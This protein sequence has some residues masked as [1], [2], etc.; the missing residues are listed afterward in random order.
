MSTIPYYY[1]P[2]EPNYN[3]VP[4]NFIDRFKDPT[5]FDAGKLI[6]SC[7]IHVTFPYFFLL[8][9]IWVTHIIRRENVCELDEGLYIVTIGSDLTFN[10]YDC[11]DKKHLLSWNSQLIT[12]SG[13]VRSIVYLEAEGEELRG[14]SILWMSYPTSEAASFCTHLNKL[15]NVDTFKRK[16]HMLV[17]SLVHESQ[18]HGSRNNHGSCDSGI[19]ESLI[20]RTNS[21]YKAVLFGK[22]SSNVVLNMYTNRPNKKKS[23]NSMSSTCNHPRSKPT[24]VVHNKLKH[25]ATGTISRS[26]SCEWSDSSVDLHL[27]SLESVN[28]S[29]IDCDS[30]TES[31]QL[32]CNDSQIEKH[33][34]VCS[35]SSLSGE[36][37]SEMI[38]CDNEAIVD[39]TVLPNFSKALSPIQEGNSPKSPLSTA[40]GT[41][42][43]EPGPIKS[44][45]ATEKR[46]C[47][48]L[49][50]IKLQENENRN[51][52]V[53]PKYVSM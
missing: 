43:F 34:P 28:K 44:D 13:Y 2:E 31:T 21:G 14:H 27:S 29:N 48:K 46:A 18:R 9:L 6:L 30:Q 23:N 53:L 49:P 50:T 47:I 40:S 4:L 38:S 5:E 35:P 26:S 1:V 41:C 20:P 22:D 19:V 37:L 51:S 25:S 36:N 42:A 3:L 7:C 39:D 10:I 15:V 12:G 33:S 11:L 8:E 24:D 16:S 52:K 32:K 45:E 17:F